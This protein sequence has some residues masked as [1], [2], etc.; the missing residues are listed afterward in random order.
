VRSSGML[1]CFL[2]MPGPDGIGE[3]TDFSFGPCSRRSLEVW[4]GVV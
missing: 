4:I 1:F 2:V 3:G